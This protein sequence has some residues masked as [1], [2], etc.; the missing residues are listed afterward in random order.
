MQSAGRPQVKA[1]FGAAYE[2]AAVRAGEEE[3]GAKARTDLQ[4][5]RR[6]REALPGGVLKLRW[7]E[8]A[9]VDCSV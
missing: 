5:R 2:L 3:A 4:A 6:R 1:A 8:G 9:T 7:F